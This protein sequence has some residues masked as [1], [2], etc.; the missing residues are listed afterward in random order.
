MSIIRKGKRKIAKKKVMMICIV[1]FIVGIIVFIGGVVFYNKTI[2]KTPD[3]KELPITYGVI[4]LENLAKGEILKPEQLVSIQL[5]DAEHRLNTVQLEDAI[6]GRLRYPVESNTILFPEMIDTGVLVA[7][8]LRKH[9]YHFIEITDALSSGDYVDIRIQFPNGADY[10]VLSKKRVLACSLYDE[11]EQTDNSLWI[12]VSEE[13]ILTLA[14]AVVDAYFNE[15]AEIYAIQYISQD[16]EKAIVTYPE[17]DIV[18]SLIQ[19]DPNVVERAITHM[20]NRVR[21][22]VAMEIKEYSDKSRQNTNTEYNNQQSAKED[23]V[24][25][26][27]T[28]YIDNNYVD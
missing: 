6:G 25:L 17:N 9:V 5:T 8:D 28:D 1:C 12:E 20:E 19:E 3:E 10:I 24:K 16:Q 2:A 26:E 21:E 14:S 22:R 4:V 13:E 27:N 11:V 18:H 15:Q 7:D 23:T